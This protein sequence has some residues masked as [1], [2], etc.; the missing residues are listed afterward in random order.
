M[1]L[2]VDASLSESIAEFLNVLGHD[3]VWSGWVM[4]ESSPDEQVV[5]R[6]I[7]DNRTV[8]TMDLDFSRIIRQSRLNGPSL[9]TL[10]LPE[11]P[12]P[13]IEQALMEH[14]ASLESSVLEGVMVTIGEKG[15][16]THPLEPD[17]T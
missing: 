13:M 2:L 5:A 12:I 16:R 17:L 15:A 14:L 7:E 3:A 4:P 8:L 1:R 6:A 10:R 9:I 11:W